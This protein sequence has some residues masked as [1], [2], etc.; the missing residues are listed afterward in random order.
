MP[1]TSYSAVPSASSL[2]DEDLF[3]VD[4]PNVPHPITG[5]LGVSRKTSMG[6]YIDFIAESA[7]VNAKIDAA[8]LTEHQRADAAEADLQAQLDTEAARASDAEAVLTTNLAAEAQA[9]S[10]ADA[11]LAVSIGAEQTR[12]IDSEAH[13]QQEID[14]IHTVSRLS[15]HPF[16]FVIF[17]EEPDQFIAQQAELTAYAIAELHIEAAVDIPNFTA[18][19][20]ANGNHLFIFN[21]AV[22]TPST[23]PMYWADDGMD[24][25]AIMTEHTVGVAKPGAHLEVASDGTL[26]VNLEAYQT[27]SENADEYVKKADD[28]ILAESKA[29][30]GTGAYMRAHTLAHTEINT[31]I[32]E[33]ITP[34]P[35][36]AVEVPGVI[37]MPLADMSAIIDG[38]EDISALS[39]AGEIEALDATHIMIIAADTDGVQQ[40]L[41]TQDGAGAFTLD[42]FDVY[43]T[44]GL[45]ISA[46][47]SNTGVETD[48]VTVSQLVVAVMRDELSEHPQE[49]ASADVPVHTVELSL[50]EQ[51][52]SALANIDDIT[53][54]VLSGIIA[55]G[56]HTTVELVSFITDSADAT[57][58]PIDK[59]EFSVNITALIDRHIICVITNNGESADTTQLSALTLSI[60]HDVMHS[61]S[62][63]GEDDV[64]VIFRSGDRP[65]IETQ[66]AVEA[67]AYL[68]DLDHTQLSNKEA[69]DQHPISAI[70]GLETA[71]Q[72]AGVLNVISGVELN[73]E[74]LTPNADKVVNIPIPNAHAPELIP[75]AAYR[76]G[77]ENAADIEAIADAVDGDFADNGET[78]TEWDYSEQANPHYRGGVASAADLAG[79]PNPAIDDFTDNAESGTE[80]IFD[81]MDWGDSASPINTTPHYTGAWS[82]S[83]NPIG[84]TP[85]EI[86]S[87]DVDG[88]MTAHGMADLAKNTELLSGATGNIQEQIDERVKAAH[89]W[90]C[91]TPLIGAKN[92]VLV[93]N[94][95]TLSTPFPETEGNY[96]LNDRVIDNAGHMGTITSIADAVSITL[97]GFRGQESARINEFNWANLSAIGIPQL[98]TRLVQNDTEEYW[99]YNFSDVLFFGFG[100]GLEGAYPNLKP[101]LKTFLCSTAGIAF[102]TYMKG[103]G[104]GVTLAGAQTITGLKTVPQPVTDEHIANKQYVDESVAPLFA[105]KTWINYTSADAT[106][107][108]GQHIMA[109]LAAAFD[110]APNGL[111]G[112]NLS[113]LCGARPGADS[114]QDTISLACTGFIKAPLFGAIVIYSLIGVGNTMRGTAI[115]TGNGVADT[116]PALSGIVMATNAGALTNAKLLPIYEGA[117]PLAIDYTLLGPCSMS[118]YINTGNV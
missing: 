1:V 118:G 30:K 42:L 75:N 20:N 78:Q 86:V 45:I 73:G 114:L 47:C 64:P 117:E 28:I 74:P 33:I 31:T 35:D 95:N 23:L 25:I 87:N 116:H 61:Q 89:L 46:I 18:V 84:T 80:W 102:D 17:S 6:Q 79:I 65:V 41:H 59:G 5:V 92:V 91:A 22:D 97:D 12:A 111:T 115:T 21:Q 52:E 63:F 50:T 71:L 96:A 70:I 11:A 68:S 44:S 90:L 58:T 8:V 94:S 40:I 83:T 100:V 57:F 56:E 3:V 4:Q 9:R 27:E 77:Y 101:R 72:N 108:W 81:G 24:T 15:I 69:A 10:D 48:H 99:T 85:H 60:T 32:H 7:P 14:D 67:V 29:L 109:A 113:I 66:D 54:V 107:P 62:I 34:L 105:G 104:E 43:Q 88:F 103:G 110:A 36:A 26:N 51:L 106:I 2:H 39:I 82:D 55:A 16:S 13:L 37:T 76:G 112:C 98:M 49:D 93:V 53:D 38:A 19:R